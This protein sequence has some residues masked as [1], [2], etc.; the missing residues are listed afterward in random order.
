MF[1]EDVVQVV[2][3]RLE[4]EDNLPEEKR[5][6]ALARSYYLKVILLRIVCK[7][8][9]YFYFANGSVRNRR[10][11]LCNSFRN[12]DELAFRID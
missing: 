8:I 12:A 3:K 4:Q 5:P 6:T 9:I 1:H 2:R 10:V 11:K 7:H